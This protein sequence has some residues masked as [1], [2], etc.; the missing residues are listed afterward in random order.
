MYPEEFFFQ[1]LFLE[2]IY[3]FG[4]GKTIYAYVV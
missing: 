1:V 2:S 3:G 4:G